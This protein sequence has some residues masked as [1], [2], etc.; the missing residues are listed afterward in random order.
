MGNVS[1]IG[2]DG[3][4]PYTAAVEEKTMCFTPVSNMAVSR[5]SEPAT[6]LAK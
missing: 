1:T 6:L 5:E 3:G 2:L 4:S